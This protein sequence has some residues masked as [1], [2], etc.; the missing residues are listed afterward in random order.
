MAARVLVVDDDEATRITIRKM[1]E[2]AEAESYEVLEAENG[3]ECLLSVEKEGPFDL[4]LLDIEMPE[5][6]GISICRAIRRIDKSLPIV[7][8]TAH[9]EVA[10]RVGAREAGGDSFVTKPIHAATLLPL[11]KV[12]TTTER[13]R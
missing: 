3:L 8:V 9:A 4:I 10:N 1:L 5:I 13:R 11:V 7:F 6:D 2:S 12:F